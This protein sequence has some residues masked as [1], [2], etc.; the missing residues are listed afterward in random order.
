MTRPPGNEG[1]S[2]SSP[3][4]DL[5]FLFDE[6]KLEER[7]QAVAIVQV[8]PGEE[9]GVPLGV[10][11]DN[12]PP[13]GFMVELSSNTDDAVKTNVKTVRSTKFMYE[14]RMFIQNS[15]NDTITACIWRF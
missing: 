12:N 14:L 13:I 15:S 11:S 6:Q 8:D 10:Y 1:A 5:S 2:P 3:R 9:L 7:K 4:S